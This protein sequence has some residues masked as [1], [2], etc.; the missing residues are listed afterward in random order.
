[1]STNDVDPNLLVRAAAISSSGWGERVSWRQPRN[2]CLWL[3]VVLIGYGVYYS[4]TMVQTG[5]HLYASALGVSAFIFSLYAIP[6]W[7]F[8]THIDRH[9]RLP[10]DL[11]VAAFAFGGFAATWVFALNG[12]TALLGLYTKWFGQDFTDN[13][14]PGLSAPFME[15]FGKGSGV[16]LLMFIAPRVVRTAFDGFIVGAFVG[17]GFEIIEDTLYALNSA[18]EGFGSDPVG[19]SLHTVILRLLTGFTSH[20]A[21]ASIFGAGL[22][23]LVGTVAQRR[24]PGLG[25]ALCAT[26]MLLHGTWD[27]T[28]GLSGGSVL[29]IYVL[30]LG[31]ILIA[32]VAVITVFHLTVG[33][34]RDIMRAVMAPELANGTLTPDELDALA[35]NRKARRRYRRQGN[36]HSTKKLRKHRLEAAHDL[37]DEI[38][39]AGGRDT[40][41]VGF[42]RAELARLQARA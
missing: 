39:A 22:V 37:A 16:L 11:K 4:F 35:G 20:I 2:A 24:R 1:M 23:F 30:L 13:W 3:F 34:E 25:L 14:G 28:T 42:A 41:R 32:A 27:A 8:T 12:N 31:F 19:N 33:P 26:S 6:F 10:V 18:P 38:A 7:W 21:Y 5:V 9:S 15:E 29:A 17:L 40:D 36:G